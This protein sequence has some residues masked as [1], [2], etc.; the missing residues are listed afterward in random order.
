MIPFEVCFQTSPS[1]FEI[2]FPDYPKLVEK[3]HDYMSKFH[4]EK[5]YHW[6]YLISLPGIWLTP[7]SDIGIICLNTH[8]VYVCVIFTLLCVVHVLTDVVWLLGIICH[9]MIHI[10]QGVTSQI[11]TTHWKGIAEH[12]ASLPAFSLLHQQAACPSFQ[13]A[14]G[15]LPDW[16]SMVM[17]RYLTNAPRQLAMSSDAIRSRYSFTYFILCYFFVNVCIMYI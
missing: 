3:H 6:N 13:R 1:Q 4:L 8:L 16:H 9:E 12:D 17:T 10:F 14:F 5:R 11:D 2:S 7:H 15:G